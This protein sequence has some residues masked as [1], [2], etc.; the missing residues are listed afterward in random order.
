MGTA[1]RQNFA[2]IFMGTAIKKILYVLLQT[3]VCLFS[4]LCP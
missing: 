1:S 4:K 2:D 3:Y